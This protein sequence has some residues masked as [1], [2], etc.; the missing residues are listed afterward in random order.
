MMML[1]T[2]L[3]VTADR[4]CCWLTAGDGDA[5]VDRPSVVGQKPNAPCKI[6]TLTLVWPMHRRQRSFAA[7]LHASQA[8]HCAIDANQISIEPA[9][10]GVPH[11]PRL[12]SLAGFGCRPITTLSSR[13]TGRRSKPVT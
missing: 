13:T 10:P 5:R 12:P 6:V 7:L 1:A 2:V 8:P 4:S 11:S 9:E 3:L